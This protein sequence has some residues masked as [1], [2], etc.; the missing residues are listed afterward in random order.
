VSPTKTELSQKNIPSFTFSASVSRAPVLYSSITI[1]LAT[2]SNRY[3]AD[4]LKPHTY[5]TPVSG[6]RV[7]LTCDTSHQSSRAGSDAGSASCVYW[8][9]HFLGSVKYCYTTGQQSNQAFFTSGHSHA[10]SIIAIMPRPRI[11]P[12]LSIHRFKSS[13]SIH[14]STPSQMNSRNTSPTRMAGERGDHK[15]M[16]LVLRVQVLKVCISSRAKT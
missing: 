15:G 3:V 10:Q 5:N 8:S 14:S 13:N 9:H 6:V 11:A 7:T 1:I 4:P 12:H 16:N 2:S